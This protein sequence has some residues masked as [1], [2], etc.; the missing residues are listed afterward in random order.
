V[1]QTLR[2][3]CTEYPGEDAYTLGVVTSVDLTPIALPD[4]MKA[5]ARI[6]GTDLTV[7]VSDP[8]TYFP[9][10]GAAHCGT[11]QCKRVFAEFATYRDNKALAIPLQGT[12]Y[13]MAS[14]VDA[15]STAF[16]RAIYYCN[17]PNKDAVFRLCEAQVANGYDLRSLYAE[18][19]Q[20]HAKALAA[21]RPPTDKFYGNEEYGGA[22][23]RAQELRVQKVHDV[24][25][26][27]IDGIR[28]VGTQELALLLKGPQPP[29]VI[30]VWG[31]AD[32]V[33]PG[34]V[35]LIAG[36]SAYDESAQDAAFAVRFAGLLKVLSPDPV[37]P[38][39]FYCMSRDCW[40]SVNAAM[41][42]RK[43]GYTDVVWYRGGWASWKAAGLPV[44]K[45][46][47]RAVV[48]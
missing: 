23:T 11:E 41:R 43:L 8:Q 45:A 25:P 47:I 29:V 19:E 32:E 42:A 34:S 24:T 7:A 2:K 22:F 18:A 27:H 35:A 28:T 10:M 31:G 17:H 15:L 9:E 40:L 13:G 14:G 33:I 5:V 1:E 48:Q 36:G 16:L 3:D 12:G 46:R 39:V 44:A 21:L 37:T 20:S 4:S 38:V 30:D 6:A 26:S